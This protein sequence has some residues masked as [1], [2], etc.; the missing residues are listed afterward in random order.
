MNKIDELF[1]YYKSIQK[2]NPVMEI[3]KIMTEDGA[4]YTI[5]G[6][7]FN[8]RWAVMGSG[9]SVGEAVQAAFAKLE[10]FKKRIDEYHIR[11]TKERKWMDQQ[12]A[13]IPPEELV[14]T[15][16]GHKRLLNKYI[17]MSKYP[18]FGF[19]ELNVLPPED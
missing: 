14:G 13:K 9:A 12:T 4:S 3:S 16:E 18:L 11:M 7:I 2:L 8:T 6:G 17:D 1:K 15:P 19:R 10:D 5:Y